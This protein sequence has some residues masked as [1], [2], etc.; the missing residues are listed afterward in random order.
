MTKEEKYYNFIVDDMVKNTEIDYDEGEVT[1]P[2]YK[3]KIYLYDID[4]IF[5]D[6]LW[7]IPH[8]LRTALKKHLI[9]KYSEGHQGVFPIW[10]LYRE[11]IEILINNG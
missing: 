8:Q 7:D 10:E 11:R 3:H 2:F 1:I 4:T 9:S 6:F 5:S